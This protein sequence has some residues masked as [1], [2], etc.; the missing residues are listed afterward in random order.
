MRS[1]EAFIESGI[2]ELY[3]LGI[4]SFEEK[5][6]AERTTQLTGI[7]VFIPIFFLFV[8]FL[9]RIKVKARLVAFL[10]VMGLLLSYEF[11][12]D[13][14]F[15]FISGWT[16][17]SPLWETFILVVIATLIEPVN[18][19]LERWVKTKLVHRTIHQ[20]EIAAGTTN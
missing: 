8:L 7:A 10:A 1:L 6:E 13:L 4:A 19:R 14:I 15:P 3:V 5:K 9:S 20:A 18:Y 17:D 16:N 2:L 11:I 12:T